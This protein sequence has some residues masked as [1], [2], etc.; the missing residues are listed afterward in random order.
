MG[1]RTKP[2]SPAS[3]LH[4][5]GPYSID[6][7]NKKQKK[8]TTKQKKETKPTKPTRTKQKRTQLHKQ[9]GIEEQL[10]YTTYDSQ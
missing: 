4:D 2:N 7:H 10:R 6:E 8:I 5:K 1:T 3:K 9:R